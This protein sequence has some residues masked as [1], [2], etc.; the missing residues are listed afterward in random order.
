MNYFNRN[1]FDEFQ[2]I[3]DLS[4]EGLCNHWNKHG[5]KNIITMVGAGISTCKSKILNS[6]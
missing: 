3:E 1:L 2:V 6:I 5:F 4:F